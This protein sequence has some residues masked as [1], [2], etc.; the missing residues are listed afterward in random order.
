MEHCMT[1]GKALTSNEIGLHKKLVNRG[2]TE[3]MCKKC[4]SA[5]FKI[6]EEQC[7]ELIEKFKRSGCIL[8]I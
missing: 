4:L 2:S 8:F 6:T 5:H 3:F 1:C 7:D